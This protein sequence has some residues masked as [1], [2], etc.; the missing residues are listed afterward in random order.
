MKRRTA[1]LAAV[2]LLAFAGHAFA[3]TQVTVKLT[4]PNAPGSTAVV[5]SPT[6]YG[7]FYVS[8]YTGVVTSGGSSQQVIL[9][10]VDFFHEVSLGEVW[11]ANKSILTSGNLSATR[12]NS[13]ELYRQ[14][15]WLT[16][17]YGSNPGA[18][19]NRTIAIQ[20]AIW[21]IFNNV[22]PYDAPDATGTG[23]YGQAYW[24]DLAR[25]RDYS[26]FDASKFYVL[27]AVDKNAADSQQEFLVYD[28]NLV[29]TPEPATLTLMGTG[30]I[31][32]AGVARRRRK[33]TQR[34]A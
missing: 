29:T 23:I 27:T 18:D 7:S 26:A 33:A 12:F 15:A 11:T 32:M 6:G 25:T 3:Q 31:A 5:W 21:N 13:F 4:A 24:M 16:Q 14:A 28:K 20:A 2:G 9:N 30:L 1:V 34:R 17:Q 22:A 10:C 19:P 8:P